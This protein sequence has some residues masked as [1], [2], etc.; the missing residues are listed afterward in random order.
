MVEGWNRAQGGDKDNDRPM[1]SELKRRASEAME[2]L[3]EQRGVRR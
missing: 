2:R 3:K 1:P